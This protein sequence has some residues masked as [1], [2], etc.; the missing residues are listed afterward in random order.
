MHAVFHWHVQSDFTTRIIA[1]FASYSARFTHHYLLAVVACKKYTHKNVSE[2][3]LP[4][5]RYMREKSFYSAGLG[6]NVTLR[7]VVYL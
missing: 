6:I 4:F 5:V 2:M 1:R 7:R 3:R